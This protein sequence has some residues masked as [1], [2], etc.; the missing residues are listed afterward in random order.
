[1]NN[2]FTLLR[3]P[4]ALRCRF[5]VA[6]FTVASGILKQFEYITRNDTETLIKKTSCPLCHYCP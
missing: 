3:L 2:R 1:M 4:N 5:T 6:W